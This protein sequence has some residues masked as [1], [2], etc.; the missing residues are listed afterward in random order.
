MP[1][2]VS[3]LSTGFS[4]QALA[5]TNPVNPPAVI[6]LDTT[7][8][9]SGA[10]HDGSGNGTNG[11]GHGTVTATGLG[12]EKSSAAPAPSNGHASPE[13]A[14]KIKELVRLAQEQGYLTYS[15]INEALPET[16]SSG[17]DLDEIYLKLRNLEVEIVDQAEV[18]R[19]K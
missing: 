1:K 19:I 10:G 8:T 9:G 17:E 5:E 11:N 4:A 2:K 16:L 14:E 3:K 12:E 7:S 6:S 15:D 13:V 18:D